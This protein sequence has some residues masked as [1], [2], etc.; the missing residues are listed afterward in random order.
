MRADYVS[1][2]CAIHA[3]RRKEAPKLCKSPV[4]ARASRCQ[5]R[6]SPNPLDSFGSN[7]DSP[8]HLHQ[9]VCKC[10]FE[11]GATERSLSLIAFSLG[12]M[13]ALVPPP[14]IDELLPAT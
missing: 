9:R 13:V 6:L 12:S 14:R 11:P 4:S 8:F 2:H 5:R 1:S 10:K 7:S 3:D